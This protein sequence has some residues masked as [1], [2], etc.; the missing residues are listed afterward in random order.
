MKRGEIKFRIKWKL[1]ASFWKVFYF[2]PIERGSLGKYVMHASGA[3]TSHDA[4]CYIVGV[5]FPAFGNMTLLDLARFY[6]DHRIR[7]YV[8]FAI[9]S[10]F[11]LLED[12]STSKI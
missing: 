11:L 1:G 3:C 5:G 12:L 4:P 2:V 8:H 9:F 10:F 6:A 7:D